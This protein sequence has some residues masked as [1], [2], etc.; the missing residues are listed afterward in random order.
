MD[1]YNSIPDDKVPVSITG[2]RTLLVLKS[3]IEKSLTISEIIDILKN[4][5][6]T[7]KS[8]SMDTARL[9][10]N[11]LRKA[12]CKISRPY[13][14]NGFKY[15]LIKNPFSLKLED[16]EV[17]LLI[18]L[19]EN[20]EGKISWKEIIN[21]NSLYSKIIE[22]TCDKNQIN[23]VNNT[24]SLG[25]INPDI[26]SAFLNQNVISKKI[27]IEYSSPQYGNEE[28]FVI[29]YK[30]TYEN[31]K[32][33]ILCYNL[34]YKDNCLLEFSRII[35]IKAINT[36]ENY[37][38]ESF[39]EVIYRITDISKDI[40][41]STDYETIIKKTDSYIEIKAKVSNE[42]SFIQRILLFGNDFKII[43]PEF[44]KEKLIRKIK[45]IQR[46]YEI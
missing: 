17:E 44:F 24:K 11:T 30:I 41:E 42:F 9:T 34:K 31:K 33:Y 40:Y 26:L 12:G 39:Y 16:K 21:L 27:L 19:R 6:I 3:L 7:Q 8:L 4:D 20:L 18:R 46:N 10:I 37:N 45:L 25:D 2:Y 43:S 32:L 14:S 29:P 5:P 15:E 28:L 36:H 23:F 35:K 38:I 1:K 22:L 13:K